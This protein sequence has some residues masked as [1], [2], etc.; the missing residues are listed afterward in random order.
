MIEE[1]LTT[2][3]DPIKLKYPAIN[4][5]NDDDGYFEE[6]LFDL[7]QRFTGIV[8]TLNTE[9]ISTPFILPNVDF[10]AIN[11]YRKSNELI[12]PEMTEEEYNRQYGKSNQSTFKSN[13]KSGSKQIPKTQE[14]KAKYLLGRLQNELNLTKEQAAG[15]V[16]NIYVE[17]KFNPTAKGDKGKV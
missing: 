3:Y 13:S 5:D 9:K 12:I 7:S 10:S 2:V 8:P 15:I 4:F 17:S 1:L 16:G 6:D 11:P 14:E